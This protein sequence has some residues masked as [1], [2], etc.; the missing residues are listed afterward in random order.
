MSEEQE[1]F[2]QI[3]ASGLP[4]AMDCQRKWAM[5]MAIDPKS[6]F[7]PV[8]EKHG[9][10][11]PAKDKN[12]IGATIGTSCHEA[13]GQLLQAKIDGYGSIDPE[14][15][16]VSKFR[17]LSEEGI[18]FDKTVTKDESTALLQIKRMV[19]AYLPIAKTLQ[20]KRVEFQL[21][22]RLDPL[23]PYLVTGSPDLFETLNDLTDWKFGRTLGSYQA[24]LGTY[25][26]TLRSHG[27]TV[28][29]LQVHWTPR[30]TIKQIQKPTQIIEYDRHTAEN[31]AHHMIEDSAMRLEKFAETG[32]PWSFLANPSSNLCSKTWCKA[33][34]TPFCDL[35]KP[36]KQETE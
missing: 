18:E 27:E 9:F 22:T 20:P 25:S 8:M 4:S 6:G 17:K 3:R 28:R 31:A 29:K 26:L 30:T 36:E 12:G 14:Y 33:W 15:V 2:I 11:V 21:K 16:A 5:D 32:N 34:G 19:Q 7:R 35:G 24:Q 23:K 10:L 1:K 13:F